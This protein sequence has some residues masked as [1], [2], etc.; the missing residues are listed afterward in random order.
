MYQVIFRIPV[1]VFDWMPSWLPDS[2]PIFGYG[3]MLFCAFLATTWLASWR[4]RKEGIN[5]VH[6]QDLAVW[7]FGLGILGARITY[8]IQYKVPIQNFFEIWKGGLVFYGSFLGG[9]IGY[10]LAHFLIVRRY[11]LS[12]WKMAD[13]IADRKSVV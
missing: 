1:R 10:L 5:K 11:G 3:L 9:L 2:I 12:F 13:V 6:I 8:M 4:A 7:I